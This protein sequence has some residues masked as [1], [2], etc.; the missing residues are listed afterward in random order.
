MCPSAEPAGEACDLTEVF[1]EKP[2]KRS[3]PPVLGAGE[4]VARRPADRGGERR[5]RH[6]TCGSGASVVTTPSR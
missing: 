4:D 3:V 6:A 2:S 5:R 1:G